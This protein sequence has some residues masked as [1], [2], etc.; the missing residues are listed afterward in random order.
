MDEMSIIIFNWN[1]SYCF[2]S[3]RDRGEILCRTRGKNKNGLS[4]GILLAL[5]MPV[6]RVCSKA[7]RQFTIT[8]DSFRWSY[9]TI[10][11][12]T[13]KCYNNKSRLNLLCVI[14]YWK[15]I[16]KFSIPQM[17]RMC[18]IY[19]GETRENPCRLSCF[20]S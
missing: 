7:K 11:Y 3:S 4:S 15:L 20:G 10:I 6:G 12:A 18:L 8:I 16:C 13:W 2:G 9:S 14:I 1:Q 19:W 5:F 17:Q